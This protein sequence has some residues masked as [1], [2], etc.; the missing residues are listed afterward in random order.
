MGQL[1]QSV[2]HLF[3]HETV[4]LY[5]KAKET[6]HTTR[7][8]K[9]KLTLDS[10]PLYPVCDK[11]LFL[12]TISEFDHRDRGHLFNLDSRRILICITMYIGALAY[13]PRLKIV[14]VMLK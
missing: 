1:L 7:T 13:V 4:H 2:Y 3:Y 12:I 10:L 6:Q 8:N 14:D 5:Y 9:G 11:F